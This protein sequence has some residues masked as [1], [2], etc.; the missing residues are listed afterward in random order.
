[1]AKKKP[2]LN[3]GGR[4]AIYPFDKWCDGKSHVIDLKKLSR[5]REAVTQAVRRRATKLKVQCSVIQE[6]DHHLRIQFFI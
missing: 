6:S 3:L 5:S 4:P 2:K 1:M